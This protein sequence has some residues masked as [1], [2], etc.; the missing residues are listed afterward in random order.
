MSIY[1]QL[2]VAAALVAA[3]TLVGTLGYVLLLEDATLLDGLYMTVITLSTVG[4]GETAPGH[5]SSTAARVFTM[6][7]ILVGVGL[8]LYVISAVTAFFVEGQ[9]TD[10]LRRRKMEKQ[11]ENISDHIIVCGAGLHGIPIIGELAAIGE[12]MV[13][14][15]SDPDHVQAALRVAEFLH[16]DDDASSEDVLE[17]AGVRRAKGLIATLPDDKDNLFIIFTARQLNPRLR[18]VARGIDQKRAD[19][20]RKAGA[21]AVVY[22]DFIGALRIVSEMVRPSAVSFL[23]HMLRPSDDP[24]RFE[25]LALPDDSP[26]IGQTLGSLQIPERTG[27]PVLAVM[28]EGD[29][30][31]LYCP[32]PET[33]LHRGA[34]LVV[35]TEREG[36]AKL[37][38]IVEG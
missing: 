25:E 11:I 37:R 2:F 32:P 19:R 8:L 10:I 12:R 27:L 4:Y 26:A 1:R 33:V 23:D 16:V 9:L 30:K 5:D 6:G 24:W 36:L 35:L 17:H 3:V 13:V 21:D 20:L 38:E 31:V 14:I 29:Q 34:H 28:E 18:L 22:P 7:L 15:E